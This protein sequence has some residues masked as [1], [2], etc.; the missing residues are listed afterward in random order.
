MTNYTD[1]E[2]EAMLS[3]LESETRAGT[4]CRVEH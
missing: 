1:Q 4:S 2:L 3:Y